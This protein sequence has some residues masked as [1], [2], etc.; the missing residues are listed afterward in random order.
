L[1]RAST[2]FIGTT[3]KKK[4][5]EAVMTNVM[6]AVRKSPTLIQVSSL[7]PSLMYRPETAPPPPARA[8]TGLITLLVNEATSAVNAVPMTTAT[9]RSTM[10]PRSRNS[11][12]PFSMMSSRNPAADAAVATR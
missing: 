5:T 4:T 2:F 7:V 8:I 9:A 1:S 10:F 3:T 11:L 12:K 6:I